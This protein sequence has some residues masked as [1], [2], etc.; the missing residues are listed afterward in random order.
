M[1]GLRS[2][3]GTAT[4]FVTMVFATVPALAVGAWRT[5][6]SPN[7]TANDQLGAVIAL[8]STDVWTTG[9]QYSTSDGSFH[10]LVVHYDGASWQVV[11][12]PEPAGVRSD[13]LTSLSAV[14]ATDIW[15]VGFSQV[16][17]KVRHPLMEHYNGSAWSV[18][19]LPPALAGASLAAV[20]AVSSNDVWA[21]GAASGVP[22][23]EHFDGSGWSTVPSPGIN[24]GH[25]DRVVAVSPTNLWAIG[26]Q[27]GAGGSE[28]AEHFDGSS[29]SQVVLPAPTV[30]NAGWTLYGLSATSAGDVWAVGSVE[31][32]DGVSFRPL[33]EHYDGTAWLILPAPNLNSSAQVSVF[34][35]V[36]AVSPTDVWAV[37]QGGP[38]N[39][40][41]FTLIEHYDGTTWQVVPSPSRTTVN[42]L[43]GIAHAGAGQL[44]ATG[45]SYP[46]GSTNGQTLV[47]SYP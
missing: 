18:V 12:V 1:R 32:A 22:L 23:V 17:K 19:T 5:V 21:V 13:E 36:T 9:T 20:A 27:S 6:P 25:L 38:G 41:F 16:T 46:A 37:G 8:S 40:Q 33:V 29:W 14:S 24:G 39:Q 35:A 30:P 43:D 26:G 15:A 31:S 4:V 28:F 7:P 10:P 45:Y 34:N 44:W 11:P 42:G 47:E 2:I 3:V